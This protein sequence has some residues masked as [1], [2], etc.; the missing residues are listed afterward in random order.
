MGSPSIIEVIHNAVEFIGFLAVPIR[1]GATF[2]THSVPGFPFTALEGSL[3]VEPM[4]HI[5]APSHHL[6]TKRKVDR[7]HRRAQAKISWFVYQGP[8]T[9]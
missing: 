3:W 6:Q 4:K 5:V 8:Q 1:R 7:Y 2:V 9:L